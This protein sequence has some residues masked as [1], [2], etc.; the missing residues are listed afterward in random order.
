MAWISFFGDGVDLRISRRLDLFFNYRS[1]KFDF[2]D[3]NSTL[4][5]VMLGLRFKLG[6]VVPKSS[7]ISPNL[8]KGAEIEPT[9]SKST[10]EAP[11]KRTA[12]QEKDVGTP[13]SIQKSTACDPRYKDL[14]SSC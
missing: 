3:G 5:S 4:N 10:N 2:E 12:R 7:E 1:S 6:N 8:A 9:K 13:G 11:R 14:F